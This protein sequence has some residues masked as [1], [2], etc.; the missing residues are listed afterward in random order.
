MNEKEELDEKITQM[1]LNLHDENY[2]I[3][4]Q[5]TRELKKLGMDAE[6]ILVE[7]LKDRNEKIRLGAAIALGI[8]I[9]KTV[10][11]YNYLL[12]YKGEK[13][14][15]NMLNKLIEIEEEVVPVLAIALKDNNAEV[16]REVAHALGEVGER[17]EKAT[18]M[19]IE[20]LKDENQEV[21]YEV[22]ETLSSTGEKDKAKVIPALI[23]TLEDD[24]QQVRRGAIITIGLIGEGSAEAVPAIIDIMKNDSE[25]RWDAADALTL[26]GQPAVPFLIE[27]LQG[28]RCGAHWAAAETLVNIGEQVAYAVPTLITSLKSNNPDTLWQTEDLLRKI[29]AQGI[30]EYIKLLD[31]EDE[32]IQ[33]NAI[34][35]LGSL[36]KLAKSA[37]PELERRLSKEKDNQ[38]KF[39]LAINIMRIEEKIG[40]GIQTLNDLK[41][42]GILTET[43]LEEYSRL[44]ESLKFRD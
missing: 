4:E 18:S 33:K 24:V 14:A 43:E 19:L 6:S 35:K 21:R 41:E 12:E 40:V 34:K 23:E 3:R 5:A 1:L 25:L 29:G 30:P 26:I 11:T 32:D 44:Y 31:E 20:A 10:F 7:A 17:A 8:E 28:E 15:Q 42:K 13:A 36:G 37:L 2:S 39:I 9:G 38:M 22:V 27:L 16:R